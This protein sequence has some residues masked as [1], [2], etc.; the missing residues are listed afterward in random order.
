M[1]LILADEARLLS[2]SVTYLSADIINRNDKC[3]SELNFAAPWN[4]VFFTNISRGAAGFGYM[5]C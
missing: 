2:Y 5:F 1:L 3:Y 4:V